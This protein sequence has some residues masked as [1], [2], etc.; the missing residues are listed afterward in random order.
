MHEG[1]DRE[2]PTERPTEVPTEKEPTEEPQYVA[3]H[4]IKE[5]RGLW[6]WSIKTRSFPTY[7]PLFPPLTVKLKPFPV[8]ESQCEI[9]NLSMSWHGS[10]VRCKVTL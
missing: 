2:E 8:Q 1:S 9:M 4:C 10:N 7:L 5:K 6:I 3:S